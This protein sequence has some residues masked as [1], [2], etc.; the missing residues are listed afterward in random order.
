MLAAVVALLL[1]CGEPNESTADVGGGTLIPWNT[2]LV[3]VSA[4]DALFAATVV[5]LTDVEVVRGSG[6]DVRVEVL[7]A[8]PIANASDACPTRSPVSLA[9]GDFDQSDEDEVLVQ[10]PCGSW[11]SDVASGV[12]QSVPTVD[13]L[14]AQMYG[15]TVQLDDRSLL[16]LGGLPFAL[17][18]MV[19]AKTGTASDTLLERWEPPSVTR[20]F[21]ASSGITAEHELLLQRREALFVV[22]INDQHALD[23]DKQR[24]LTQTYQ[25]PYTLPFAA[26]DSLTPFRTTTCGP[27][28]LGIGVFDAPDV[29]IPRRA[30]LLRL[31]ELTGETYVAEDLPVAEDVVTLSPVALPWTDDVL[32]GVVSRREGMYYFAALALQG[33]TTWAELGEFEIDFDIRTAPMPASWGGGNFARTDHVMLVPVVDEAAHSVRFYHYDGYS[34]RVLRVDSSD[35]GAALNETIVPVHA[36]R[37]DLAGG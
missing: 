13:A 11:V 17:L 4:G 5:G 1:G 36:K 19:D 14:V 9:S 8:P 2:E 10:D 27:A 7:A 24:V 37:E 26:Y 30:Q 15:E 23:W 16:A 33:C 31:N 25:R 18:T 32:V 6:E 22:P 35:A 29:E 34:I 28:A 12:P 21:V 3:R 20:A